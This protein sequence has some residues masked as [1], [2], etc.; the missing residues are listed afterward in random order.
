MFLSIFILF[1][2]WF[3]KAKLAIV[4][5]REILIAAYV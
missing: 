4:E 5:M 3:L 1:F 2:L